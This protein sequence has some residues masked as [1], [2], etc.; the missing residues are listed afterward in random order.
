M[1]NESVLDA[2]KIFYMSP[3]KY[4]KDRQN[5]QNKIN[6]LDDYLKGHD[7]EE[8]RN[9]FTAFSE[10]Y[11]GKDNLRVPIIDTVYKTIKDDLGLS[12]TRLY[13]EIYFN[14]IIQNANDLPNSEDVMITLDEDE[15][16]FVV[17]FEYND[18]GFDTRNLI[19]FVNTEIRVKKSELASTGKHGVGIKSLFYF[20]D[21]LTIESNVKIDVVIETKTVEEVQETESVSCEIEYNHNRVNN[22]KTKLTIVFAKDKECA[23]FNIVKLKEFIST[24]L[25]GQTVSEKTIETYFF[26][27]EQAGSIFDARALLFTDKNKNKENGIKRIAFKKSDGSMLFELFRNDDTEK[28]IEHNNIQFCKQSIGYKIANCDKKI[29]EDYIVFTTFSENKDKQNIS[30]A[31]PSR[32][33][34]ES[35]RY[36]STY[37]IPDEIPK[38]RLNVLVNSEYSNVSRTKLTDGNEAELRKIHTEIAFNIKKAYWFMAEKVVGESKL[39]IEISVLFHG[40]LQL[41]YGQNNIEININDL[42]GINNRYLPKYKNNTNFDTYIAFK[43][44]VK[45]KYEKVTIGQKIVDTIEIN[46]FYDD[47]IVSNDSLLYDSELFIEE[48]KPIYEIAFDKN[49]FLLRSILNTAGNVRDMLY[50]RVTSEFPKDS[51]QMFTDKIVDDWHQVLN[52][53]LVNSSFLMIGRYKLHNRINING[54]ITGASFFEYLFND[55]DDIQSPKDSSEYPTFRHAQNGLYNEEYKE[56]RFKLWQL[57]VNRKI[58]DCN[59]EVFDNVNE[60]DLVKKHYCPN[61]SSCIGNMCFYYSDHYNAYTAYCVSPKIYRYDYEPQYENSS[62]VFGKNETKLFVDKLIEEA[63]LK[64][65]VTEDLGHLILSN[66]RVPPHLDYGY[67]K[68]AYVD[69][70]VIKI[71]LFNIDFLK[72]IYAHDFNDFKFYMCKLFDN[73]AAKRKY[74]PPFK[75]LTSK[76]ERILFDFSVNNLSEI[77]SFFYPRLERDLEHSQYYHYDFKTKLVNEFINNS[78]GYEFFD[79]LK[80]RTGYD[81]YVTQTT[82]CKSSNEIMFIHDNKIQLIHKKDPVEVGCVTNADKKIYIVHGPD[83]DMKEAV[84]KTFKYAKIS[85][86]II[87]FCESFVSSNSS[88]TIFGEAYNNIKSIKCCTNDHARKFKGIIDSSKISCSGM[89][90]L[91]LSRGNN[92]NKCSCCCKNIDYDKGKLIIVNNS[93]NDTQANYPQII[94]VVCPEC[95]TIISNSLESAQICKEGETHFV[96]YQCRIHNS[97]QS[98]IVMFRSQLTDGNLSICYAPACN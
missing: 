19:G 9:L 77:F 34:S 55:N 60:S 33:T 85:T 54:K 59:A 18:I 91:L 48:I 83:L 73:V 27:T 89:V 36:Y 11:S 93:D 35:E 46:R 81:V 52:K 68:E 10:V 88:E 23:G 62:D 76:N 50:Y 28:H 12:A 25:S 14:E 56:L 98:K 1:N 41:F 51:N 74:S 92:N 15:K 47:I 16:H 66:N 70:R 3:Q 44:D 20:V 67:R 40:L 53:Q 29:F 42:N 22:N 64:N 69:E 21:R 38:Y 5:L 49:D 43:R 31:F 45:E 84:I 58:E 6:L 24:C 37:Y 79:F 96:N 61:S 82:S 13:R 8:G 80:Q 17:S 72:T 87:N 97:V 32:L 26:G 86:D 94:S 71:R 2:I 75:L 39:G 4:T 90:K 57:M 78:C 30:F 65:N 63:E 95:K 7:T